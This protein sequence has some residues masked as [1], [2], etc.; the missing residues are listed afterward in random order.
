MSFLNDKYVFGP[1]RLAIRRRLFALLMAV[2]VCAVPFHSS[3]V[4]PPSGPLNHHLAF[5]DMKFLDGDFVAKSGLKTVSDRGLVLV[6]GRFGKGITTTVAP[7]QNDIDNMSGS[8]STS[9]P[10]RSSTPGGCGTAWSATTN[11]SFGAPAR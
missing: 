4:P 10:R 9:S 7:S 1:G 11:P 3:A 8:T 5:E 2:S 6:E